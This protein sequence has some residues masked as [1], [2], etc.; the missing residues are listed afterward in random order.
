MIDSYHLVNGAVFQACDGSQKNYYK[1]EGGSLTEIKGF[2]VHKQFPAAR[3]L[4]IT[5]ECDL[6]NKDLLEELLVKIKEING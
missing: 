2:E 5:I 6:A 1:L 3:K 4:K